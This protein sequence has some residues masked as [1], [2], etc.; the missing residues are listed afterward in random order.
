M[1]SSAPRV[2]IIGAGIGG[3][4]FAIALKRK[5]AFENFIIYEKTGAVGGAWQENTYPGCSCDI[6]APFYSLS[7]DQNP[8]WQSSHPFQPEILEYWK[9]LSHKYALTSHIQVNTLVVKAVWDS[10]RNCYSIITKDLKTGNQ[11]IAE[12][13]I[14]ISAMGIL[15]V[16]RFPE[17][18]GVQDFEGAMFHSARW[19]D[20]DLNGKRVAIIGN[21]A[22]ASQL[23]PSIAKNPKVHVTQFCRTANWLFPPVGIPH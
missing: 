11:S 1:A 9:N 20:M 7:S 13:E 16:P 6:A 22:S 12:A 17:I 4:A 18:P 19:V 5:F 3:L 2:V 21:G 8:E 23:L 15:E 14:L 10:K